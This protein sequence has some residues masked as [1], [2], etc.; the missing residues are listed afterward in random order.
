MDIPTIRA[1]ARDERGT[2]ASRRL[3]KRRLVPAVLY[4]RGEPN[5]LLSVEEDAITR[6]VAQ[7]AMIL[8]VEWDGHQASTQLKAVQLDSLGDSILHVDFNRISL[9]ETVR[10]TVPIEVHGEPAGVKEQGGV[11]EMIVHEI[12]VECLPTSIPEKIR[13]DVTGVHVGEDVRVGALQL[14]E[15]IRALGDPDVVVLLVAMPMEIVE[16]EEAALAEAVAVE[17]EVIGKK[18]EPREEEEEA[19][20]RKEAAKEKQ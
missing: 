11:L 12:E 7:H 5:V 3:R 15:G 6:L 4:G 2:R 17:P 10:V 16:K 13:V 9:T 20:E 1:W 19:P 8:Q 18:E 14:P